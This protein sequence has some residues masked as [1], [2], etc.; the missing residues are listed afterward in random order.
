MS[1]PSV[2]VPYDFRHVVSVTFA[3]VA[4]QWRTCLI[5]ALPYVALTALTN[6]ATGTS[7]GLLDPTTVSPRQ[8]LAAGIAA[9]VVFFGLLL[10]NVLV[11][12]ITLGAL[13]QLGSAAA[14]EDA[15]NRK[16]MTRRALDRSVEVIAAG[17]LAALIVAAGPVAVGV[18]GIA[19][20]V[21]I[22]GPVGFAVLVFGFFIVT[23][24]ALYIA[25]RLS[26]V[27]PIVMREGR[28]P[29][30]ALRRSWELVGHVWFWVFTI[31]AILAA[32][33]FALQ[34]VLSYAT[35]AIAGTAIDP[36]IG[37]ISA[38]IVAVVWIS[39]FGVGSG[40]IYACRAPEDTVPPDVAASEARVADT[41]DAR[42]AGEAPQSPQ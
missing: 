18:L 23:I 35:R 21:A 13:S 22:S 20:A 12:P 16:G 32:V 30:A 6:L 41:T 2:P 25:V 24:P 17:L 19:A 9:V 36:L 26:L 34:A 4:K 27:I 29:V 33:V 42:V 3:T 11:A 8:V 37:A 14:Y 15:V 39:L 5:I 31:E 28:G 1:D 38:A 40:V 7:T 10:V